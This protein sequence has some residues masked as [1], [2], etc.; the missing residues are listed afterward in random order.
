MTTR[1]KCKTENRELFDL[2]PPRTRGPNKA[3][4]DSL[5]DETEIVQSRRENQGEER[6][7]PRG[8]S[9]TTERVRVSPRSTDEIRQELDRIRSRYTS[10]ARDASEINQFLLDIDEVILTTP[11]LPSAHSSKFN[12]PTSDASLS[13]V[14][15]LNQ[16]AVLETVTNS[17]ARG[18]SPV[19]RFTTEDEQ[20]TK[21]ATNKKDQWKTDEEAL[22]KLSENQ[23]VASNQLGTGLGGSKQGSKST[24]SLNR[25]TDTT[26]TLSKST[27]DVSRKTTSTS[28][29]LGIEDVQGESSSTTGIAGSSG[30]SYTQ[31]GDSYTARK[32][33]ETNQQEEE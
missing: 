16:K 2:L 25:G 28:A 10:P 8:E 4:T 6:V 15:Q 17:P 29:T 11:E 27:E 3:K 24:P 14:D 30:D 9:L 7:K 31:Q 23:G 32:K 1:N 18:S 19:V 21:L 20:R 12:T 5:P 33:K 22:K 26:G 13:D